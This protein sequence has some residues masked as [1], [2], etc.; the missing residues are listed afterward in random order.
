[1]EM[2]DI[3]RTVEVIVT[4]CNSTL[5]EQLNSWFRE[6]N[7]PITI[8]RSDYSVENADCIIICDQT[9]EPVTELSKTTENRPIPSIVFAE[10]GTKKQAKKVYEMGGIYLHRG[11]GKDEFETLAQQIKQQTSR[12]DLTRINAYPDPILVSENNRITEVNKQLLELLG[13]TDRENICG[14]QV[15]EI[16]NLRGITHKEITNSEKNRLLEFG[17]EASVTP[18]FG[19]EIPVKAQ[20]THLDKNR[21]QFV[22]KEVRDTDELLDS[23]NELTTASRALLTPD[24]QKVVCDLIVDIATRIFHIPEIA[25]WQNSTDGKELILVS[26]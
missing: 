23:I 6:S 22:L 15:D 9:A 10:R 25:V 19:P 1:M 12:R 11:V 17:I 16:I 20:I 21:C 8:H 14:C 24:N 2:D 5:W 13:E 18:N 7:H 4:G 26:S 3:P